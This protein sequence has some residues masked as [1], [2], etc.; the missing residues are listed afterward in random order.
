MQ[1]GGVQKE[2]ANTNN[3]PMKQ[4]TTI[5]RV[6][7]YIKRKIQ[8]TSDGKEVVSKLHA[9]LAAKMAFEGGRLSVLDNIS[10]LEWKVCAGGI[11]A[12]TLIGDFTIRFKFSSVNACE[13]DSL[14]VKEKHSEVSEAV[15]KAN[16]LYKGLLI[17]L[18]G[19]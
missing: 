12:S 1:K 17:K 16:R 18:L 11:V 19:L 14:G 15:I 13:L 9:E 7:R 4:K 3:T 8:K 2:R 6:L 5:D 10:E